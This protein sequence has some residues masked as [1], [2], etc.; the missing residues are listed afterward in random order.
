MRFL[1]TA[2]LVLVAAV[3]AA[4]LAQRDPGYVLMTYG[5]TALETSLTVLVVV[6]AALFLAL[7]FL[8]RATVNAWHLPER[9]RHWRGERRARRARRATQRGLI[10]LAEGH[11]AE[12]ENQLIRY[13]RDSETP[14]LN[15]LG[16]ARAAQKL[17]SDQR[18]DRYLAEAHQ[19]M[20]KAELA[21]GLTQAEV[22][23]SHGQTEQALA[24]LMHLHSIAP[25]H[26]H[27][28]Y[29]LKRLYERLESWGDMRDLLPELRRQKVMPPAALDE[30]ERQVHA[31]LLGLAGESG[32]IERLRATWNE[33]P[34]A[35][36]Q[37]GDLLLLYA[38]RLNA[39]GG[40]DEAEQWVREAVKREWRPALVRLYGLIESSDPARQLV[41]AEGWLKNRERDP[42]LLLAAGRLA[43]RSD[44]WGK[45]RGYLEASLGAESRAETYFE[46]GTL[47]T[48]M[49]EGGPSE[50]YFRKGLALAVAQPASGKRLGQQRHLP[51]PT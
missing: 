40:A 31:R 38:T 43:L 26:A 46:L 21:V 22:Q 3:G 45:A 51:V 8:I 48:Q 9:M 6:T 39:L 27:V 41:H 1:L 10:A 16:A 7:Y 30:L 32:R 44:L 13:A 2:M 50:E 11:W 5:N 17:S 14:L 42:D 35:M 4:L 25:K 47:L 49:A 20:P 36:R 18:R 29:L 23:L 24:T 37:D 28:L 15:Y 34:K 33:V 12:A 19:S